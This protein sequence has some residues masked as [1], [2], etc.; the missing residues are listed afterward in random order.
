[1]SEQIFAGVDRRS[2]L[3]LAGALSA[4]GAFAGT[5][6][7]CGGPSSTSGA[8]AG[9]DK[10]TIEAGISYSLS[11]GFDPMT[12]SGATPVAANLHI[13]EGLVD[14]DPATREPYAALATAMPEKIDDRTYRATLREGATFHDGSPVTVD[15]VVYSFQRILAPANSS[16]MAQ[17]LPFLAEVSA[18]DATTVEFRLSYPFELFASRISVAKIVPKKL[19]EADAKGFDAKPVGS[20]PFALVEATKQDKIVF[21]KFEAYNGPK[22]AKVSNM[23][24]RLVADSAA[25]VSA[26]DS[27]RV[28]A[29]EDVPYVD[30]ARV[31]QKAKLESVQ[32]FGMLF[33]MFNCAQAPFSDKRVRQALHY[34]VDYDKIIETAMIG[35]GTAASSYLQEGHP[36]YHRA[37]TVYAHD[38]EKAR[39]LLAEAGVGNLSITLMTTDTGW[40]KDIAPLL[41]ESFDAVGVTTTLD[42][43]ES[44]GQYNK[45]EA[46]DFQVLAAPGDPSVFGNDTDLLLSWFYASETWT[47]KRFR[48]ADTP[49][50]QRVLDLMKQAGDAKDDAG[51]RQAWGQAIDVLADE[52]PLYPIIHRKLPTAWNDESLTGFAPL[53][54]T[55]LSFLDTGRA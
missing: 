7:A 24:W 29:I 45:V 47:K 12:S 41:K 26:M 17:F 19:V 21:K 34:A 32:S 36:E 44:G 8:S 48:W 10:D 15:D 43:N 5:L 14:L 51:R 9:G 31:G 53:P 1:M 54:T 22:P 37:A 40:V 18:P 38:P 20:G 6:S 23:I 2:F 4:A 33:L 39:A 25:R 3:R 50:H 42:S 28:V 49:G 16:L 55:G 11:T 52:V 30:V 13:F 35:N 46:G 27:G